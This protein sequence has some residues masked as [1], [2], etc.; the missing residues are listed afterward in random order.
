VRAV[1][2]ASLSVERGQII[3]LVGESGCGKSTLARGG[4]RAARALRGTG[5][6]RGSAAHPARPRRAAGTRGAP[7]DGLPEPVRLAQTRV[8]ASAR[9]SGLR[10]RSEGARPA[11]RRARRRAARAGRALAGRR[12]G[13]TRTSSPAASASASRSRAPRSPPIPRASCWTSRSRRSMPRPRRR[14]RNLLV[15]LARELEIGLLLISHDL[16]IVRHVCDAISVMYLG[17][18]VESG[19][20]PP[21]SGRRPST[22]TPRR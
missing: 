5:A 8:G 13:A 3:G 20:G 15:R 9:R 10:C 18:I 6:V 16:A 21:T 7:A 14:S 4:R 11:R 2:G 22:R 12:A 19:C 1:A 17:L